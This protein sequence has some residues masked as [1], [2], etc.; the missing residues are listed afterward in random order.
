[1][2]YPKYYANFPTP[3]APKPLDLEQKVISMTPIKIK[4]TTWQSFK[5][6]KLVDF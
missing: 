6:L 5:M 4:N 2:Q 3:L 1:M